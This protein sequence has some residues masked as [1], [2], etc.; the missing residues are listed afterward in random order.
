MVAIG[1]ALLAAP[2][3]AQKAP[4][5]ACFDSH[6]DTALDIDHA[7]ITASL[8]GCDVQKNDRVLVNHRSEDGILWALF[9]VSPRYETADVPVPRD[10]RDLNGLI[11][12]LNRRPQSSLPE[13]RFRLKPGYYN[14][15]TV[16]VGPCSFGPFPLVAASFYGDRHIIIA[17]QHEPAT[18]NASSGELAGVYGRLP[19]RDLHVMLTGGSPKITLTAVNEQFMYYF[20]GVKPGSYT[21]SVGGSGWAKSLGDVTVS[22]PGELVFRYI[23]DE[24]IGP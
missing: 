2:L 19:D 8:V 15:L 9:G 10:Q 4:F 17:A 22:S 5:V 20:D 7:D 21:L 12:G 3:P 14:A 6:C 1:L 11:A 24:E 16:S 18:Q 23:H 13:V